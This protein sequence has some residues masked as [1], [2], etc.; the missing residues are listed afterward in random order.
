MKYIGGII[1]LFYAAAN[2]FGWLRLESD[3]RGQVPESVRRGPG[4]ILSWHDGFMGG[5]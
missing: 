4:G 5:K 2:A 3:D 1:V